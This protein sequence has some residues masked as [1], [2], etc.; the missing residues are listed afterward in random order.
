MR[1]G[2][3]VADR[4][5]IEAFASIGGMGTIYRARDRHGGAVAIKIL[6]GTDPHDRARFEREARVLAELE[7]P[8]IVRYVAQ[9]LTGG[10]APYLA[11]EWLEGEDVCE[12]LSLSRLSVPETLELGQRVAE[13]LAFAHARGVV[14]RDIKPSNLFLPG[15]DIR[16]VKLLD[17]GIARMEQGALLLTRAG[18]VLGTPAYMAPEQARGDRDLDARADVFALG[19]VLF[20]CLTGRQPFEG[21]Q[22]LAVLAKIL[23]EEAP[24]VSELLS[25]VPEA[26]NDIIARMLAKDVASRPRDA[27]RLAD[28]LAALP[29]ERRATS[30]LAAAAPV[31]DPSEQA[32]ASVILAGARGPTRVIDAAGTEAPSVDGAGLRD[33]IEGFGARSERLAD[34]SVIAVLTGVGHATELAARAARCA[35][36]LRAALPAATVTLASGLGG[37]LAPRPVGQAIDRAVALLDEAP[38]GDA[39]HRVPARSDGH[40]GAVIFVDR[41]TAGMLD[42]RFDV[43]D[44]ANTPVLRGEREAL[45]GMVR[46]LLGRLT[47]C[48]GRSFEL[49]TLLSSF[50][51]CV[52]ESIA[53]AVVVTG[54]AGTGKSRLRYEL[55]RDIH[56]RGEPVET[57][58]ARGDPLH[59]GAPLGMVTQILRRVAGIRAGEPI[60]ASQQRLASRVGR[61]ARAASAKIPAFLGEIIGAPFSPEHSVELR[62]ARGDAQLMGDQ[63]REA[64]EALVAAECAA[65]PLVIVLEDLHWGDLPSVQLIDAA[66]RRLRDGRLFVLAFG[67]PELHELFPRLWAARGLQEIALGEL[68]RRAGEQLVRSVLGDDL[69]EERV[70]RILT[71]AKGNALHIEELIR[72]AA[73]RRSDEPMP[74]VDA[75]AKVRIASLSSEAR[76]ALRAASVFGHTFWDAGIA[77]LLGQGMRGHDP[78]LTIH[79]LTQREVVVP[80]REGRFP[81]A[82]EFTFHHAH[83]REAAYAALSEPDR[84]LGHKLAAAWLEKAGETDAALLAE[85]LDRAGEARRA[86]AL[87]LRAAEQALDGGDFAGALG[88]ARRGCACGAEGELRGALL[89]VQAEANKCVGRSVEADACA[90]EAVRL[91]PRGSY[92]WFGAVARMAD[93]S[94]RIGNYDRL[95][96]LSQELFRVEVRGA[97]GPYATA[98]AR[99][100]AQLFSA[101]QA[102]VGDRLLAAAEAAATSPSSDPVTAASVAQARARRALATGDLSAFMA[103]VRLAASSFE[104]GGAERAALGERANVAQAYIDLGAYAEAEATLRDVLARAERMGV[105][106][107]AAGVRH[108]LALVLAHQGALDG[109]LVLARTALE[110]AIAHSSRSLEGQCRTYRAFILLRAGDAAAAE[111]EARAAGEIPTLS[112]PMRACALAALSRALLARERA[113]DALEAAEKAIALMTAAHAAPDGELTVHLAFVEALLATDQAKPAAAALVVARD[114]LFAR[115]APIGDPAWKESFLARVPDNARILELA[116]AHLGAEPSRRSTPPAER[117]SRWPPAS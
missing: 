82:A 42:A 69:A 32:L 56:L 58:I 29:R 8:G 96:P 115:A 71:C 59:A 15:G 48:V 1:A 90:A 22:P 55:L 91:L 16:R 63:I 45:D 65:G 92:R 12:R 54:P 103:A 68:P 60:E 89:L 21:A 47:P 61:H 40:R 83:L 67:R 87:Y 44:I 111:R 10:G 73:E 37:A 80:R 53:R 25:E 43:L 14:H 113:P 30:A 50:A 27:E 108:R 98:A 88:R 23:F 102:E 4:F 34:G 9:G 26:V 38:P 109:A 93:A 106:E 100:A 95:L 13:A 84:C 76:R 112:P 104:R 114:R 77:A 36:A 28:E 101:G 19:C 70:D 49:A 85:H 72:A 97:P 79:E 81:G 78:A 74:T 5:T 64:W 57:W 24:R 7:H 11:M 86:G 35:L 62:A 94:G 66:L 51:E 105:G 39:L 116:R 6:H 110:G 52:T 107:L 3:V 75:L 99:V 33:A 17:F 2:D 117:R 46:P 18:R 41:V 20:E 31:V